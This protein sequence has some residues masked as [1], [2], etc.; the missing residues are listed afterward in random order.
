VALGYLVDNR[1]S[2][3][4]MALLK[5][6][7]LPIIGVLWTQLLTFHSPLVQPDQ[8]MLRFVMILLSGVPTATTQVVLTQVFAPPG[9]GTDELNA[10]S[11]YSPIKDEVNIRFLIS[12]YLVMLISLTVL[13]GYSLHILF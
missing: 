5:L 6:A 13:V 11:A 2:I 10:L 12:Q 3:V 1:G 4:L 9:Q 7:I 8:T